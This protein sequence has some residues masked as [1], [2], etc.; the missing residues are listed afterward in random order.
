[1]LRPRRHPESERFRT[2]LGRASLA[3]LLVVCGCGGGNGSTD[4]GAGGGVGSGGA[5]GGRGG[6]NVGGGG[7]AGAGRGGQD[8]AGP[9]DPT[10]CTMPPA[11]KCQEDS[12]DFGYSVVSYTGTPTCTNWEGC[13]YPASTAPCTYGCYQGQCTA[14]LASLTDVQ[15][16]DASGPVF[17][18][19]GGV[20]A[21]TVVTVTA[22]TS[23]AGAAHTVEV[24]YGTCTASTLC[25]M[26]AFLGMT[27]DPNTP[28]GQTSYDQWT[29]NLPAESSG[30]KLEF[31][32]KATGAGS[33]SAIISQASTGVP[34]SYTSN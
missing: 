7:I 14:A 10:L 20:A 33:L 5:I 1:M 32:L 24:D 19:G 30:T 12:N 21:N 23:P 17:L 25:V 3:A 26:T 4:G 9:C 16:K 22:R 28:A 34:W 13:I 6:G 2:W 29:A 11:A 31:Q 15:G 8:A 18:S 27:L